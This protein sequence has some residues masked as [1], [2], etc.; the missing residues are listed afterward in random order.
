[1][2]ICT[3]P[4]LKQGVGGPASFQ[5]KLAAGLARRGIEVTYDLDDLPF[6]SLLVINSTRTIPKLWW[7]KKQ[8]VHIVQRLGA[9]NFMHRYFSVGIQR[10]ILAEI[11]NLMMSFTR[12]FIAAHI[13]YQSKFVRDW[14]ERTYGIPKK[15]A[16]I[17]YNGV[18]LTKFTPEGARY[19]SKADICIISVEGT[20]GADPFNTAI[21]LGLSLERMG[22]KVELLMF[23]T[24]LNNFQHQIGQYSFINFMGS[25]PNSSLPYF[26][27]GATLYVFTDIFT[28]ACPNSVIEALACGTPV[29]GYSAGI[30]PEII[31]NT[32]AGRCVKSNG[33]PFR[34]E[35]PGNFQ[36]LAEAAI[37]IAENNNSFRAAARRLAEDRYGLDKMADE[38]IRVLFTGK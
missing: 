32:L 31:G 9:I 4:K 16:N 12:S 33:D 3:T 29:L 17:I 11:R 20:Q 8:G 15:P 24:P 36:E 5:R 27:R 25:F 1:M 21:K 14:W 6:D 19:Q 28:G 10:Y 13:V 23:G 34:G 7:L 2:R 26:Y 35:S 22:L 30:L 38:Y 37:E 18:D